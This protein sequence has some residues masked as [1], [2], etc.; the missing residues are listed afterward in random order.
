M[1]SLNPLTHSPHNLN[2]KLQ[3]PQAW[4]RLYEKHGSVERSA[5]NVN[6]T[7]F[8]WAG[9][10]INLANMC[11]PLPPEAGAGMTATN[12]DGLACKF[13]GFKFET[14]DKTYHSRYTIESRTRTTSLHVL[15]PK[16]SLGRCQG[17]LRL[18]LEVM[19]NTHLCEVCLPKVSTAAAGSKGLVE[20]QTRQ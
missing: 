2:H 9:V 3:L 10:E 11:K 14:Q 5:M 13:N 6:C 1:R 18:I 4:R 17:H 12:G 20:D 8:G 16:K 15:N 19:D 7:P